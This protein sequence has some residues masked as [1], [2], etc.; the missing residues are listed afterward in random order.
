MAAVYRKAPRVGYGAHAPAEPTSC[1]GPERHPVMRCQVVEITEDIL[2]F[3]S[4][5]EEANMLPL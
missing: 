1:H 5:A 4:Q 3:G 2:F